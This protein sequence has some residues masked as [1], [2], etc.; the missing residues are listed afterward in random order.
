MTRIVPG[1]ALGVLVTLV[2]GAVNPW[3][4]ALAALCGM[5]IAFG[6]LRLERD[7]H[8]AEYLRLI[9][10]RRAV[11]NDAAPCPTCNAIRTLLNDALASVEPHQRPNP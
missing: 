3:G 4:I 1:I 7:L 2:L 8:R 9:E 11:G 10:A 6:A 5:A